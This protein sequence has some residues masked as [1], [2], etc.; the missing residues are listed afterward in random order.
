MIP[1]VRP[2]RE[3]SANKSRPA[4]AGPRQSP[5]AARSRMSPAVPGLRNGRAHTLCH[6]DARRCQGVSKRR[7]GSYFDVHLAS[8]QSFTEAALC[9]P[10][11]RNFSPSSFPSAFSSSYFCAGCIAAE[12]TMTAHAPDKLL[13]FACSAAQAHGLA[14]LR[15]SAPLSS[16]NL[17]GIPGRCAR[18]GLLQKPPQISTEG[19]YSQR[20]LL[21]SCPISYIMLTTK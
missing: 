4:F 5:A 9:R 19:A 8:L 16:R 14:T 11:Y 6:S 1:L 17:P 21:T 2:N 13:A 10:T 18:A 20:F 7:W 15:S 12:S 3:R